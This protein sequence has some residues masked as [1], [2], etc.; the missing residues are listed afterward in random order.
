MGVERG[1]VGLAMV[2]CGGISD[3]HLRGIANTPEAR[4]V[5]TMD[6]IAERAEGAA[7]KYGGTPHTSLEAVWA[8]DQVEAVI[9]ALPHDLHLPVTLEAAQAG[10]H[11]LVEKPMALDLAEARL[12]VAA[13][14]AAGVRLMVGQSTRF[15]PEVWAAKQLIVGGR[16]GTVRQCISQRAFF[17]ERLSTTWRLAEAQCG[18]MYLP[19]FASHDVDMI[20]WLMDARPARV[21]AVLRS[22]T[23]LVESESDGAVL[24]E[25]DGDRIA[26]LAFSMNSH[27]ARRSA[28]FI[29]TGG[30]LLIDGRDLSVGDQPIEVDR[31]IDAFTRQTAEFVSAIVGDREPAPSGRDALATM[32][33][34]DAAKVSARTGGASII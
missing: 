25:F 24:I 31:S 11:I 7:A 27:I 34:L 3:A 16:I 1:S 14:Q 6:V 26:S 10:K 19:L 17:L 22:F 28:L 13:A 4:L 29:G 30:T 32:A 21:H 20:W 18:G 9:L 23:E 12:M 5:A 2:G 8:D 33:V 15:Q